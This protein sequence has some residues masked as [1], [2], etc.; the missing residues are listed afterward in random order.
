MEAVNEP[1]K[2]H[3]TESTPYDKDQKHLNLYSSTTIWFRIANYQAL[4][5]KC[6]HTSYS[7]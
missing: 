4:M 1:D 2:Q 3:H 6:D 5:A 7:K